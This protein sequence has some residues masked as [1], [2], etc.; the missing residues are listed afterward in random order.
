MVLTDIFPSVA[1]HI[2]A[3]TGEVERN[4][5]LLALLE[6][7]DVL[8]GSDDATGGF[9]AEDVWWVRPVAEPVPIALPTVPVRTADAT[10]ENLSDSAVR[11][12]FGTVDFL[13]SQRF[14]EFF[15]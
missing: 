15:E 8:A 12:R 6:G 4:G 14:L 2:A 11:L 9:V 3:P 10:A 13:Y 7:L 1:T 5:D